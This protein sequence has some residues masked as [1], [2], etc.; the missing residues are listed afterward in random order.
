MGKQKSDL[1]LL[2]SQLVTGLAPAPV[3]RFTCRRQFSPGHVGPWVGTQAVEG[4][5]RR[6]KVLARPR[7]LSSTTKPGPIGELGP[8][9]LENVRRLAVP[10]Q[11]G[12]EIAVHFVIR[13]NEATRSRRP[14]ERPRLSFG[15][16]LLLIGGDDRR[17]LLKPAYPQVQLRQLRRRG[18]VDVPDPA[19]EQDCLLFLEAGDPLLGVAE[20]QFEFTNGSDGPDLAKSEVKLAR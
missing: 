19:S 7:P 8:G 15:G 2:G 14:G 9:G 11:G 17:G 13:G 3:S 6:P 16:R 5:E 12:L 20:H 1:E 18:Q 10:A 4:V